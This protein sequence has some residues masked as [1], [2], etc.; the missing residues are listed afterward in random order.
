MEEGG[1]PRPVFSVGKGDSVLE[2]AFDDAPG[3]RTAP[4]P[5]RGASDGGELAVRADGLARALVSVT[6]GA[7]LFYS[8]MIEGDDGTSPSPFRQIAPREPT[9]SV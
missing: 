7:G 4:G 9:G 5:C 6:D 3:E 2:V 1:R 8:R